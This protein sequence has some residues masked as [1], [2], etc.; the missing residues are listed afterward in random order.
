MASSSLL[1]QTHAK[2]LAR[3]ARFHRSWC[4]ELRAA[5]IVTSGRSFRITKSGLATRWLK[6]RS[7]FADNYP[8]T[9]MGSH[10]Q[11]RIGSGRTGSR[12]AKNLQKWFRRIAYAIRSNRL[13]SA[14]FG[15]RAVVRGS[16]SAAMLLTLILFGMI[17]FSG[18]VGLETG[19]HH[20]LSISEGH[21]SDSQISQRNEQ[22]GLGPD[23]KRP[24][25]EEREHI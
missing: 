11:R 20:W 15:N 13:L 8:N 14:V 10:F 23:S 21:F 3:K 7:V 24:E 17:G 25:P 12:S 19:S 16:I 1:R 6:S 18:M 5:L 9:P 22:Q 4:S 2:T